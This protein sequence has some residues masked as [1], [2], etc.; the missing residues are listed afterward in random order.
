MSQLPDGFTSDGCTAFPEVWRGIDLTDCC[1]A[2]DL[3]WYDRPGDWA[4]WLHSNVDLAICFAGKGA[5]ELTLP[6]FLAVT[7]IGAVLFTRW[8]LKNKKTTQ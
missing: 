8:T 3:A 2:H 1:Y 4:A 7:T 5:W 6:A